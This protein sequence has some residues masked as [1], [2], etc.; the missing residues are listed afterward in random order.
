MTSKADKTA[1]LGISQ[2]GIRRISI[3]ALEELLK[4]PYL[5]FNTPEAGRIIS[6]FCIL[7]ARIA[8][9][10]YT[11]HETALSGMSAKWVTLLEE[12]DMNDASRAQ[13]KSHDLAQTV[14][15]VWE[16]AEIERQRG[17]SGEAL[18][19]R[20]GAL[21]TLTG[22]K[23]LN[24]HDADDPRMS[25][26]MLSREQLLPLSTP[27][28]KHRAPRIDISAITEPH[29]VRDG[30]QDCAVCFEYIGIIRKLKAC[31]HYFCDACLNEWV[32]GKGEGAT[33][34]CPLCKAKLRD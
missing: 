33:E 3:P 20:V 26:V 16:G 1:E 13:L 6:C 32:N 7:A 19:L 28:Q 30:K 27:V 22:L 11:S 18:W 12:T 10:E 24:I 5:Q 34:N 8:H 17:L 21:V 4:E 15:R 23:F 29:D 31:D 9:G 25:D 14:R 2:Q